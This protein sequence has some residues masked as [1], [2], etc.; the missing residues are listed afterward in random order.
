MHLE[1]VLDR[2]G[3]VLDEGVR[4]SGLRVEIDAQLVGMVDVGPSHRPRIEIEAAEVDGPQE[5]RHV[6]GAELVG[7]PSARELHGDG[8][9]PLRSLLR[10]PL[11]EEEVARRTLDVAL[12][13]RRALVDAA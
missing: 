5:V 8:L 4:N 6:D 10:H 13:D 1:H 7:P 12:Q 2:L 3:D 11:L 9:E